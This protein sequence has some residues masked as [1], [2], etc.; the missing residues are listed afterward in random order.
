MRWTKSAPPCLAALLALGALAGCD[1][2]ESTIRPHATERTVAR[3]VARHTGYRPTDVHCPSGI[4]AEV[5]TRFQCR[6]TGPDG[7]YTA[8]VRVLKV[9]GERVLDH[10]VTRPTRDA[11]SRPLS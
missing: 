6:F 2:A 5:G 1:S 4:P 10:I 9:E 3:F 8:Y 11:G 7:P